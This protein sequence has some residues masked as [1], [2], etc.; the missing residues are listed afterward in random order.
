LHTSGG[1]QVLLSEILK[2]P[3]IETTQA[4]GRKGRGKETGCAGRRSA[5]PPW[6]KRGQD[7]EPLKIALLAA[8]T[9][10]K[11]LH[12]TGKKRT[13][14]RGSGCRKSFTKRKSRSKG[15]A[16]VGAFPWELPSKSLAI[17]RGILHDRFSIETRGRI[18]TQ[19]KKK[20]RIETV[21][22]GNDLVAKLFENLTGT[23]GEIMKNKK[24]GVREVKSC[25]RGERN[26]KGKSEREKKG[27]EIILWT[28][29]SRLDFPRKEKKRFK[30]R[31]H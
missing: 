18:Y 27:N 25:T 14:V 2:K 12:Q 28:G 17:V 16:L 4:S 11:D 23:T 13:M 22:K 20:P 1:T 31:Q 8:D 9:P 26:W 29:L 6:R 3:S 10:L 5:T 24:K 15:D 21:K 30:T 7:E 19:E